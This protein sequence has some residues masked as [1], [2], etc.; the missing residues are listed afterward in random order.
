[1]IY[2]HWIN[3]SIII[4]V[5]GYT[6]ICERT[7]FAYRTRIGERTEQY[8]VYLPCRC[9][10][11]RQPPCIRSIINICT[12]KKLLKERKYASN[13]NDYCIE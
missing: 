1:M 11:F 9:N 10:A 3:T 7:L 12:E 6:H 8:D 4:C 5:L 13:A 2:S